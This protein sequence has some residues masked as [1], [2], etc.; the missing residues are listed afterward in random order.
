MKVSVAMCVRNVDKYIEKCIN[1]VLN[2]SFSDFEIVIIDDMS[3]DKTRE[4]IERFND[5]RVKL[6]KN[7]KW[8]GIAP[9][10]NECLQRAKGQFIFF[11]DGDCVVCE[12][13]IKEGLKYFESPN[14]VGVEGRII[15]VSED[16]TPTFSDGIQ[17]NRF[18]GVFMTGNIAYRREIIQ[19]IGGFDESLTYL[20]DRDLGFR[21][22]RCGEICFAPKMIVVHPKTIVTPKKYIRYSTNN[23]N[24]VR[25]FKNSGIKE[26]FVWRIYSPINLAKILFP[27]LIFA[28]LFS[29]KFKNR[30]DFRL[31]P[32]TY[33]ILLLERINLWKAAAIERVFLV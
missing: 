22:L 31:F 2:Q 20:E 23:V 4:I 33:V 15:Y 13:W 27:P 12:N 24:R 17:E 19:M 16:Y 28:S 11:T 18:G 32:Y 26:F 30:N 6:F 10:R 8:L 14:V 1:S 21:A 5:T 7:E 9:S 29:K 3:E 25:I